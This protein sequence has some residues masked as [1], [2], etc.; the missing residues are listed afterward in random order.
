[1]RQKCIKKNGNIRYANKNACKHFSKKQK[2][3]AIR[4]KG[5]WKEIDFYKR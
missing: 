5:G 4:G 3:S 2:Q 1:M